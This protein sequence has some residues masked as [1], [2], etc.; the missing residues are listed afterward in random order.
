MRPAIEIIAASAGSG[1]T[2]RLA[3]I[4]ERE[5]A[6]GRVRP[7]GVVAVTFTLKAA[8]ELAER[9]RRFLVERGRA[10]EAHR[11]GAAR[12]GSVHAV[13]A[14]LLQE[15]AFDL[16]L[17]PDQRVLED[18]AAA[19]ALERA[20]TGVETLARYERLTDLAS[21]LPRLDWREARRRIVD[22]A[23]E[24]GL[25]AAALAGCRD[26]SLAGYLEL[27]EPPLDGADELERGLAAALEGFLAASPESDRTRATEKARR[28][29]RH[30]LSKLRGGE[31]L[32][33]DEWARLARFDS[34]VGAGSRRAAAP[35]AAA[36][37]GYARH[38]R[39][40]DDLEQA[41]RL[42]FDLSA[43]ALAAYDGYKRER[44]AVDFPDQLA[45]ALD[46]LRRTRVRRQ[47]RREID[48]VLVDEFQDTSPIQLAIFVELAAL[49]RRSVWVGD[50][51]QAIYGFLGADPALMDAVLEAIL[52]GDEPETLS[53]SWRSRPAL[54]HLT[55]ELFAPAF[56]RLGI[57]P[58][59]TR[60]QPVEGAEAPELGPVVERWRLDSRR[61][62]DD[63][64]A[65]AA[66]V[67]E[68]LADPGARVRERAGRGSR[69]V[70][71]GDVAV[72]CF[73]NLTCYRVAAHLRR[74]GVASVLPRAG[75][76]ATHEGQ[77]VLAGLARWAD[78]RDPLAA[79]VLARLGG[80]PGSEDG[81][82]EA[83]LRGPHGEG[84]R[85]AEAVERLDGA[86]RGRPTAGVFEAFDRVLEAV[87]ARRRVAAWGDAGQRLANLDALRALAAR[88]AA[89][90][91]VEEGA[92]SAAGLVAWLLERQEIG[93]RAPHRVEALADPQAVL[94]AGEAVVVSTWHRAKGLEWP[95]T[96]LFDLEG[97]RP[98][99]A[100]GV[101][102]EEREDGFDYESPLAGRW[103]RFWPSPFE[104]ARRHTFLHDRL[105]GHRLTRALA[106]RQERERLRLLYVG[107]T[108]A[109]DRV[110][111]ASRERS[112]LE[113]LLEPLR[114]G[115]RAPVAEP[116]GETAVWAGLRLA[117]RQRQPAPA[118]P[119]PLAPEAG[120]VYPA[121]G[122]RPRPPAFVRPSALVATAAT[123]P[124]E[125]LGERVE[126][127]GAPDMLIVGE[128]IHRFFAADRA[129]L[130]AADRR[131]LAA[132]LAATWG[133][134]GAVSAE[135]LVAAADALGAWVERRLPGAVWRREWPLAH[136]LP[137]GSVVRGAADLVLE[138][139]DGF[140]L[141]DH[142]AFPGSTE[143]AVER[144]GG[145]AGQLAAY[146]AAFAAAT[147]KRHRGSFIHLPVSALV[148]AVGTPEPGAAVPP[149]SPPP[150]APGPGEAAPGD[151]LELF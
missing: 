119:P 27:L 137:D 20:R 110:V 92:A 77:L 48:L 4:L 74:L 7:E 136:R 85:A 15:F 17:S 95:I 123:G 10:D 118:E 125:S 39:L 1:K 120:E 104:P 56:A 16:G 138:L 53:R 44:G 57:P 63:A 9:A 61:A 117:V 88:Y 52:A 38:P 45:L 60:L 70:R 73:S 62:G 25:D 36:A 26:R 47:L 144:A 139:P 111:L 115:G 124:A 5:L 50:Q 114:D 130:A 75:L 80:R 141:V 6:A 58:S 13:C 30:A 69:P 99:G 49:A 128:V 97:R 86:R 3:E 146:A 132:A 89:A 140:V 43:D 106:E 28:R 33:W 72:L 151:Q 107:W 29:A 18:V 148:V 143:Q 37:A 100:L 71:P 24:N 22:A 149:P 98:E 12:I 122:P 127:R 21:R 147:G 14:G 101:H 64:A 54:V 82:L 90:R 126:L 78:P 35:L 91:E 131:Q 83:A 11:L 23:R 150:S 32:E 42:V 145:F 19:T 46:L 109:R 121:P 93:Q 116:R 94:T 103:I 81:W 40:R 135:R 129:G 55:S 87:D 66:G 113:R 51:K 105:D 65:L 133:L 31:P 142:K 112:R 84:F 2:H 134:A 41:V 59:R 76:L 67:V 34:E 8:A 68:L 79:A 102:V 96:V 108:R